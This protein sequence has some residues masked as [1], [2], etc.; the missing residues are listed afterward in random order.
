MAGRDITH[1]L[2]GG[3]GRELHR[4][5]V[6]LRLCWRGR[7]GKSDVVVA[8]LARSLKVGT[9]AIV[10]A[11]HPRL[12]PKS[13]ARSV[14]APFGL[15][16][17]TNADPER[18][19][20]IA[21]LEAPFIATFMLSDSEIRRTIAPLAPFLH[22]HGNIFLVV[23]VFGQTQPA[24]N[25]LAKVVEEYGLEHRF[26]VLDLAE[27]REVGDVVAAS[28]AV[29]WYC[30]GWEYPQAVFG[31]AVLGVPAVVAGNADWL[32]DFAVVCEED[33]VSVALEAVFGRRLPP[34]DVRW[35]WCDAAAKIAAALKQPTDSAEA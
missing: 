35:R 20:S 30:N 9:A 5:G 26:L 3:L 19:R 18:G 28:G 24:G 25:T 15:D 13:P 10:Y 31:A 7:A 34:A 29:F 22:R 32:R 11:P 8:G 4:L 1:P 17:F 14:V 33:T 27:E 12:L 6:R 2:L 16:A 23:S 21:T